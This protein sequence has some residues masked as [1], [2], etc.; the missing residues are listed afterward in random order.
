VSFRIAGGDNRAKWPYP[1]QEAVRDIVAPVVAPLGD[2]ALVLGK[3]FRAI[4][5]HNIVLAVSVQIAGEENPALSIVEAQDNA[6]T[7]GILRGAVGELLERGPAIDVALYRS[8]DADSTLPFARFKAWQ[9]VI[10]TSREPS[11]SGRCARPALQLRY[12]ADEPPPRSIQGVKVGIVKIRHSV[13]SG[14][15]VLEQLR[16]VTTGNGAQA[17]HLLPFA[18]VA[19]EPPR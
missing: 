1:F 5:I 8:Q 10:C 12:G 16:V 7:V 13:E 18:V 6:V 4:V 14:A 3:E 9:I 15:A 2:V 17:A 19:I 11:N